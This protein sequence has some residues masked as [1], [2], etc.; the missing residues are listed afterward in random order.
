[1]LEGR[2]IR[3]DDVTIHFKMKTY[4]VI[5]I[6]KYQ[7]KEMVRDGQVTP[8]PKKT[9]AP[10]PSPTPLPLRVTESRLDVLGNESRV[11]NAATTETLNAAPLQTGDLGTTASA[12]AAVLP[13]GGAPP[14]AATA[15]AAPSPG[16]AA[17]AAE[18]A[19]PTADLAVL[20]QKLEKQEIMEAEEARLILDLQKRSKANPASLN[21]QEKRAVELYQQMIGN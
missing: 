17:P 12:T 16:A 18:A 1:M 14:A 9:P 21:E 5:Q 13:P 19:A 4:G 3:E 20:I 8:I 7:I 15:P 2:I 6:P 10:T 11:N